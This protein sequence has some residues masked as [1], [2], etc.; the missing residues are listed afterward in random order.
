MARRTWVRHSVLVGH[1]RR[2]E[3]EGVS[4]NERTGDTLRLDPGHVARHTLTTGTA[5]LVM[6]MFFE[7]RGVRAI[8]RA[9]TTAVEAEFVRG[10][11]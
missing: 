7:S 2:D 5:I 3:A 1:G 10:F 6:S 8:R 9:W 4:A 11:A